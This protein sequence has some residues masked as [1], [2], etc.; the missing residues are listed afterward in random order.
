[1]A[2]MFEWFDRVGYDVDRAALR[3]EFPKLRWRSVKDWAEEQDWRSALSAA[4]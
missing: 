1:M 4:A 3:R 2:L